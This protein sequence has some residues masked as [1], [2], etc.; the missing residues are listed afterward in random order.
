MFGPCISRVLEIEANYR[1][2]YGKLTR[3]ECR[4]LNKPI[5]EAFAPPAIGQ[6]YRYTPISRDMRANPSWQV[7][8]IVAVR[9]CSPFDYVAIVEAELSRGHAKISWASLAPVEPL[10][11]SLGRT[12]EAGKLGSTQLTPTSTT[13]ERIGPAGCG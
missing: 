12:T 10:S 4:Q 5:I 1:A 6:R 8:Q 7:G 3:F 2:M 13:S 9:E 11:D